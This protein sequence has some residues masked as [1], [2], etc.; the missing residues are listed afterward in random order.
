V[1]ADAVGQLAGSWDWRGRLTIIHS[2]SEPEEVVHVG[3]STLEA[4][5]LER[6]GNYS[7]SKLFK[8]GFTRG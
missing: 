8:G 5:G 2:L 1:G 4:K 3:A 7:V 6:K